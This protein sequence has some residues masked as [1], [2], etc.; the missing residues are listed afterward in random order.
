MAASKAHIKATAKYEKNNYFKTLVRFKKEDEERI[1]KAA[2]KSL[3]GFIVG[4]VLDAI[5]ESRAEKTPA[6]VSTDQQKEN[7]EKLLEIQKQIEA[8]RAEK[9]NILEAEK[10]E[11]RKITLINEKNEE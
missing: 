7:R 6:E 10:E 2:G 1:R 4:C 3:N 5:D 9:E 8:K 11:K